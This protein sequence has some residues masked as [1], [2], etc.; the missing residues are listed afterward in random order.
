M[1]IIKFRAWYKDLSNKNHFGEMLHWEELENQKMYWL[2]KKDDNDFTYMQYTGL[3]DKK[4]NEIYEGDI[5]KIEDELGRIEPVILEVSWDDES[6]MFDLYDKDGLDED[7]CGMGNDD[8]KIVTE[9]IG[10]IYENPELIKN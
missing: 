7:H 3:T 4:G 1:R 8:H 9:V 10:N 6:A 5:V 2:G